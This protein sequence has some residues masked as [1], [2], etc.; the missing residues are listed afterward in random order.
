MASSIV[1]PSVSTGSPGMNADQVPASETAEGGD[2]HNAD[3]LSPA[4][5][6]ED[7]SPGR[8]GPGTSGV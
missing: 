7:R 8:V 3:V 2:V 5:P 6:A 4:R 1:V